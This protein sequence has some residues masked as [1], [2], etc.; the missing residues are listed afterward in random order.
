[1]SDGSAETIAFVL[2]APS[3]AGKTT[4]AVELLRRVGCLQRTVSFT[5]REPRPDE[6]DGRDYSFVS[7]E[8]FEGRR[9]AGEFLESFEVHGNSYATPSAELD[10]I[11]AAGDD[12]LMVIDVQGAAAVRE[13]LDSATTIFVLPPSREILQ[14]RL[15][16]RSNSDAVDE[17]TIRRRLGVAVEEIEQFVRYDYLV[18]NDDFDAAV[19]ELRAIVLAERCRRSRRSTVGKT[20]LDS[21]R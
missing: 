4:L 12:A 1:M 8:E 5:T 11:R 14:N 6:V 20:I 10:R 2:S 15:D 13:R 3:G 16:Q 21:F 17:S 19:D 18:V 9:D 7:L